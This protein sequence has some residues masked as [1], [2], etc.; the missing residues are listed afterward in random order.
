MIAL[1]HLRAIALAE[2]VSFLALLLVAMPLKYLAG[3]PLAVR[4]VGLVHGLLFLA[5]LVALLRAASDRG[6]P[7][8]RSA[9]AFLSSIVPFGTF[10]FDR[11]LRREIAQQAPRASDRG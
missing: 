9:L 4:V 7:L 11:S 10:V 8:R 2:G 6:W 3:F 1:R 5:F